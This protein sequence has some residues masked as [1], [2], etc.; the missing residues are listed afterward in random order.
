MSLPSRNAPW[1]SAI[2]SHQTQRGPT[3]SSREKKPGPPALNEAMA[4]AS[5]F[6]M[7]L[8]DAWMGAKS[9]LVTSRMSGLPSKNRF[10]I[11]R[12]LRRALSGVVVRNSSNSAA[13]VRDRCVAATISESA[14]LAGDGGGGPS[15][16]A[17][18]AAVSAT[19]VARVNTTAIRPLVMFIQ[20]LLE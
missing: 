5:N 16:A 13:S 20:L 3:R 12:E 4:S 19:N 18:R 9:P 15:P 6:V 2:A 8:A 10:E 7:G 1:L 11:A 17:I 14:T